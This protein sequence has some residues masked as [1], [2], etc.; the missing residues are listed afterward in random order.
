MTKEQFIKGLKYLCIA[1]NK[2][3]TEEQATVWY[4]FFRDTNFDDFRQAVKRIIPQKEFMPSIAELKKEIAIYKNPVLQ[5]NAD[6]EW[7]KAIT[8]I[9]KYGRYRSQE[10][11]QELSE[12]SRKIIRE[13]G[14]ERICNSSNIEWERKLFVEL[15]NNNK[16]DYKEALVLN[17]PQMTP[18]ELIRIAR[19]KEKERVLI[20]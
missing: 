6:D 14:F 13:I 15:F 20:E 4:D 10:A 9:R 7:S 2:E 3:F 16:S 19:L 12:H 8:T 11:M 5:L 18:A 1:Y 17:E